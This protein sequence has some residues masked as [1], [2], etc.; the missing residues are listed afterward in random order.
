MGTI[1]SKLHFFEKSMDPSG[2]CPIAS[3]N[4]QGA[5]TPKNPCVPL[6]T[7]NCLVSR[8]RFPR[9]VMRTAACH[10]EFVDLQYQSQTTP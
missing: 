6:V 9:K 10:G 1:H 5:Q 8:K 4:S 7:W 2:L 3:Y